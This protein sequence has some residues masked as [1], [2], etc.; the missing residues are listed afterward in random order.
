MGGLQEYYGVT[1]DLTAYGKVVGGG[2]PVGAFGGRAEIMDL[3]YGTRGST[4]FFQ[5]G[6]F[7]AHPI[8]MAA[9]LATLKQR[10]PEAFVHMNELG[11]RLT[12]GLNELF[13]GENIAAKAVNTGSVFSIHFTSEDLVNYRSLARTD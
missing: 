8:T 3:L 10:T 7:S 1:P 12:A 2:F 5:S 13:A 11:D 4:G 9:G 6:T